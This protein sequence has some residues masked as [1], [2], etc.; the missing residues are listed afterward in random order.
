MCFVKKLHLAFLKIYTKYKNKTYYIVHSQ[1]IKNK[2]Q[3][4]QCWSNLRDKVNSSAEDERLG[5]SVSTAII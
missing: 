3:N 5:F 1:Y 2:H 4:Q